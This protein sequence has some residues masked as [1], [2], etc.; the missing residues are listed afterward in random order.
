MRMFIPD[1]C[2]LSEKDIGYTINAMAVSEDTVDSFE[3]STLTAAIAKPS[4]D[5]VFADLINGK[6]ING[7]T[8]KIIAA[9]INKIEL[10]LNSE[11]LCVLIPIQ[12]KPMTCINK[13]I[14]Q[15]IANR[16]NGGS[17]E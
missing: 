3:R 16:G 12:S 6:Y 5:K 4:I 7:A 17:S 10:S 9:A 8:R 15:K 13:L 14:A 11:F 2:I 1:R